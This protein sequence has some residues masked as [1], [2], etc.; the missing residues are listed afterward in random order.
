MSDAPKVFSVGLDSITISSS[1]GGDS[2]KVFTEQEFFKGSKGSDLEFCM[3]FGEKS[4]TLKSE[5]SLGRVYFGKD[6]EKEIAVKVIEISSEKKEIIKNEV[7]FLLKMS[8]SQR[9]IGSKEIIYINSPGKAY[10]SYVCA[11]MEKVEGIDLRK[12][13]KEASFSLKDKVKALIDA[14]LGLQ[15]LHELGIVHRDVKEEN[16]L[17]NEVTKEAKLADL[18]GC[19]DATKITKVDYFGSPRYHSPETK[20]K[21]LAVVEWMKQY[22]KGRDSKKLRT[23]R[24]A[25]EKGIT[26]EKPSD[27]YNFGIMMH[28]LLADASHTSSKEYEKAVLGPGVFSP[29]KEFYKHLPKKIREDVFS[30]VRAC[31]QENPQ[32]RLVV[33]SLLEGLLGIFKNLVESHES[34]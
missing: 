12:K 6:S 15:E 34:S 9:V 22:Q 14:A 3:K 25:I 26:P 10:P 18:G 27:I 19:I 31:L 5:G 1:K 29:A 16:V 2:A 21:K 17:L 20:S 13:N 23:L 30:L 28:Q 11:V 8:K 33:A 4:L 32:D 7:N 24:R